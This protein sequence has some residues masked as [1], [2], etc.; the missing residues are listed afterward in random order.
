MVTLTA[1]VTWL[2]AGP[3]AA[4]EC[5]TK[6]TTVR[7][8]T[9][10]TLCDDL[11]KIRLD[12]GSI[13]GSRLLTS[14]TDELATGTARMAQRLGLTGLTSARSAMGLT[15]LGGI[16]ATSGMPALTSSAP[17]RPGGL[18]SLAKLPDVPDLPSLPELP[19]VSDLPVG[20]TLGNLPDPAKV[21]GDGMEAP[22]DMPAPVNE[23]K[24]DLIDRTLPQVPTTVD[25]LTHGSRLPDA[26]DSLSGLTGLTDLLPGLGMN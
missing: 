4:D 11:R 8:G 25:G 21:A 6:P 12:D 7:A 22:L 16:A 13:G 9:T 2:G 23:I 24:N 18:P 17:A 26:Q 15:D 14:Q 10:A 1:G 20:M 3:V 5:R 19:G